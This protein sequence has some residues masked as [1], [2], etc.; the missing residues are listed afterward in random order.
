MIRLRCLPWHWV[1]LRKP[2]LLILV[3]AAQGKRLRPSLSSS[4]QYSESTTLLGWRNVV[5]H[6]LTNPTSATMTHYHSYDT[7]DV[8]HP[9]ARSAAKLALEHWLK[10]QHLRTTRSQGLKLGSELPKKWQEMC[11]TMNNITHLYL[12]NSTSYLQRNLLKQRIPLQLRH[13]HWSLRFKNHT[14]PSKTMLTFMRYN[15]VQQ[16]K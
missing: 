9:P 16:L 7:H 4:I 14:K 15:R 5:S 8:F 11:K 1:H 3:G 13:R 6:S 10:G 2:P 12:Q